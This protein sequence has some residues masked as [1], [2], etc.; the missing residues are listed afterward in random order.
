MRCGSR[1]ISE[2]DS[3]EKVLQYCGKPTEQTRTYIVRRPRFERGGQEY[4][5]PGE[6]EV[7]VDLWT[8]DFGPNKLMMRVRM[9]AGKVD[10]IETLE[11]GTNR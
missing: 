8:Y 6:E 10:S 7:P 9:I 11:Y 5:F 3:L 1:V 2:D 4:S